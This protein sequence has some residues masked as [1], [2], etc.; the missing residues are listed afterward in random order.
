MPIAD[1]DHPLAMAVRR[2]DRR[3]YVAGQSGI[4]YALTPGQNGSVREILNIRDRISFGG[5]QGLLGLAFSP[6]GRFL[7]INY[8]DVNG[9]TNV[10]ECRMAGNGS[11]QTAT[12]RQVLFVHQPFSNHN[13]GDLVCGP[14]GYL[15]IGL[16]D[17]GS[18]GDPFGNG[19]N[20]GTLLGKMLRIDPRQ[21]DGRPYGIPPGNP[22]IGL[23][24]ARPEIWDYGLRNP[25]RY[26]FD[27][28][29]GDLWIGD[30][31]QDTREEIDL[32]PAGSGGGRNY[33][34]H[35][36]EGR[37]R[38]TNDPAPRNAIPPLMDYGHENGACAVTGGYDYRGRAI[39]SLR[40]A[41]LYSDYCEGLIMALVQRGGRVVQRRT[42]SASLG[43]VSSFGQD[44]GGE[45][46]VLTLGGR[47]YRIA[48]G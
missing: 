18:G 22:F 4:V 21:R 46:Y 27:R 12:R 7:Y 3:L 25:W 9:D 17:G 30:V 19:Q 42:L 6:D 31:G 26:S 1:L 41:Y 29:T 8:T 2:G 45:L 16:G 35:A 33:G 32:E 47:V 15:Y 23:S 39:P 10:D 24:G 13:G 40:G 44:A 34:W 38:Y 43:N 36:F 14:D 20:L 28:D 37:L 5:E 48:P 11:V